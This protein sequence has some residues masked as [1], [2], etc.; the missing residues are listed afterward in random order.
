VQIPPALESASPAAEIASLA[1]HPY[2][3]PPIDE[4][5]AY[6]IGTERL[7]KIE[8][9]AA[10]QH[11]PF[12]STVSVPVVPVPTRYTQTSTRRP[13]TFEPVDPG[14]S[15]NAPVVAFAPPRRVTPAP[16]SSELPLQQQ[17]A[18]PQQQQQPVLAQHALAPQQSEL[19]PR[20]PSATTVKQIGAPRLIESPAEPSPATQPR[21]Q[22]TVEQ[23][24]VSQQRLAET[25][26][27][28]NI[29]HAFIQLS[30]LYEHDQLGEAERT[31]IQP[32]LDILAL[33]VIFARDTHI[34]EPPHRVRPGETMETIARNFHLTPTLLRKI[35]GFTTSQEPAPG[36]MLKVVYGQ[37]DARISIKRREFTLLLGGLYAGRFS[38]ALPRTETPAHSGEFLITHKTDRAITLNNGWT[39]ASPQ[40][41]NATIIFTDQDAREIFSILSEQSVIVLE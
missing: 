19:S 5:I 30:Q 35:N 32:I 15:S 25:G 10:S 29:R 20:Q 24:I 39:L 37:F 8:S 34:L 36:T 31:L 40:I 18:L 16:S 22:N 4:K 38:F 33:G 11:D 26:D 21:T 23:F 7:R 2:T 27:P 12:S 14:S 28:E 9:D 1:Q 13:L 41:T 17:S 3:R 6:L